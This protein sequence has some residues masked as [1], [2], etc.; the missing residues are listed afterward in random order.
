[1]SLGISLIIRGYI[2]FVLGGFYKVVGK[3]GEGN[4]GLWSQ[5]YE[6]E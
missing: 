2:W 1:M 4:S 3:E 5:N 6:N